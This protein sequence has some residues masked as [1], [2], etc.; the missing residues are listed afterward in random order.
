[1]AH[2][3]PD[4][5]AA[6]HAAS[7]R[8]GTLTALDQTSLSIHRGEVFSLLG[9]NGA[10]KSTAIALLLGLHQPDTGRAE[11]F[12]RAPHDIAARRRIGVMLQ[13]TV[14]PDTLRVR[15]LVQLTSSYYPRPRAFEETARLAGLDTLLDRP[16]AKLSGGQQRRVQFA[17]A[18]CG[19]PQLLFLD[20]P[21]TG[22]DIAAREMLWTAVRQ[23][24]HEGCAV[25]LTTHY[26]EEAEALAD[27]I[28][29]L[30][31]GRIVSEGS[32]DEIRA[33]SASRR[34]RCRST[35]DLA[36]LRRLPGV[37]SVTQEGDELVIEADNAEDLLRRLLAADPRLADLEVRRAG[38][39][40]AFAR[41]TAEN[42][43]TKQ[44]AA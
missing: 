33:R 27:R 42:P 34:I 2:N 43:N 10:G 12:G 31:R 35:L 8:Y 5:V 25:L 29:V 20:E 18:I 24:V 15:E 26:L 3:N 32:L 7:K 13:T 11:L 41:I 37:S 1:M 4:T 36:L 17:L 16:Y 23:M 28:A 40:E 44:E 14:L 39:A 19:R 30:A 6:L 38:L 21:T 9:P 22:L